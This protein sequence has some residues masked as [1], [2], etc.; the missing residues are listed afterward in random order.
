ML[1]DYIPESVLLYIKN[2]L[3]GCFS[4]IGISFSLL[5]FLSPIFIFYKVCK[6]QV[7]I[8]R[9]SFTSLYACFLNCLFWLIY[10]LRL[11]IKSVIFC[12]LAGGFITLVFVCGYLYLKFDK[13]ILL[14]ILS[15][16][17][18]FTLSVGIGFSLFRFVNSTEI[19]GLVAMVINIIMYLIPLKVIPEFCQTKNKKVF[20]KFQYYASFICCLSWTL[21]SLLIEEGKNIFIT[22]SIGL[23]LSIILMMTYCC[24]GRPHILDNIEQVKRNLSSTIKESAAGREETKILALGKGDKVI[25]KKK[26]VK[27]KYKEPGKLMET[28]TNEEQ[29]NSDEKMT[30]KNTIG[31]SEITSDNNK[32]A[33]LSENEN[34]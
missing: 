18:I 33:P 31:L 9:M 15:I 20:N 25:S 4:I 7:P 3:T 11:E 30:D 8:K 1:S 27:S 22:N 17:G 21:Y 26:N 5:F 34:K 19:I 12:N 32:E 29:S 2:L 10:G 28:S 16:L 23:I 14:K 6:S 24:F 13:Q